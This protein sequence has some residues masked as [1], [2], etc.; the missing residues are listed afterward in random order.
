MEL[1]GFNVSV[2][3]LKQNSSDGNKTDSYYDFSEYAQ[4]G[5]GQT[6][7][8]DDTIDTMNIVLMGLPFRKS[9]EPTSLFRITISQPFIDDDNNESKFEKVYDYAL[10]QDD[11]EQPDMSDNHYFTHNLTLCNPAIIA[12]QRTVDNI[13]VT[14]KLQDVYLESQDILTIDFNSNVNPQIEDANFTDSWLPIKNRKFGEVGVDLWTTYTSYANRYRFVSPTI[15]Y[16]AGVLSES[17]PATAVYD[18]NLTELK[19]IKQN[20]LYGDGTPVVKDGVTYDTTDHIEFN[21]PL[22]EI[23][24]SES[25]LRNYAFIGYLPVDIIV[26]DTN[27]LSG[28]RTETWYYAYPSKYIQD[29]YH[30]SNKEIEIWNDNNVRVEK[31]VGHYTDSGTPYTFRYITNFNND[32]S[33]ENK[34][35]VVVAYDEYSSEDVIVSN[36]VKNRTI[37]IDFVQDEIHQIDIRIQRHQFLPQQMGSSTPKPQVVWQNTEVFG[38]QQQHTDWKLEE[39]YSFVIEL[40]FCYYP[41]DNYLA[42]LFHQSKQIDAYYLFKKSQLAVMPRLKENGV[43]YYNTDLPFFVSEA[44]KTLL[45]RTQLIESDFNGKNLW[46]VF[47]E[48]GKYIHAKPRISIETDDDNVMTGRFLVSFL[49]YGK[50]DINTINATTDSIFNSRFA[51]EYICELDNYVENYFNLGS[52]VTEV[53]HISSD[54]DDSLIYNDVAKLI[55][56]YPIL[57][58]LSLEVANSSMQVRTIT[59]YLYEYNIYKTLDYDVNKTPSKHRAI[60]YHLG[61]NIIEGMQFVTPQPT[62]VECAYSMKNIIAIAFGINDPSNITIGDYVFRLTYRVKDNVR[63]SITRP[64]LRKY[65]LNSSY[66]YY[67]IHAQFNQQQEKIVSSDNFGLNAYGKLIRTGN[68]TYNYYNWTN[69]INNVMNEGDLYN[70]PDGL[71]YVSKV[72]RVYY[73]EH[74]EENVELTKDFN[75]LSQIIGIPSEPRFYEISERNIVNRDIKFNDYIL[76]RAG[77][78]PQSQIDLSLI[79]IEMCFAILDSDEIPDGVVSIFKGDKDKTYDTLSNYEN[80][81]VYLPLVS[82]SSKNTLTLEWDMEDNYSAGDKSTETN[83]TLK[84]GFNLYSFVNFFN[85]VNDS[86]AYRSKEPVRYVDNYGRADL[87]DFFFTKNYALNYSDSYNIP[88]TKIDDMP[89][90]FGQTQSTRV[91]GGS[92]DEAC[93]YLTIDGMWETGAAMLISN[94]SGYII[95]KDNRE[96]LSFN[97]NTQ[98]LLDSDRIVLGNKLWIRDLSNTNTKVVLLNKELNK[99]DSDLIPLENVIATTN[100]IVYANIVKQGNYNSVSYIYFDII[101][102]TSFSYAEL[103]ECMSYALVRADLVNSN[104]Y[105]VIIGRNVSDILDTTDKITNFVFEAYDKSS[106]MTNRKQL[107]NE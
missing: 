61:S 60:Y 7:N 15:T 11:V 86:Q 56:K 18:T 25:G 2:I 58:V 51:Q 13:S 68:T 94:E 22:I 85:G 20:Y 37:R 50:P 16:P 67:P 36:K 81:Q 89:T 47:S 91:M 14:Y 101:N 71:Y 100:D 75:R 4:I 90:I 34:E 93:W 55:T 87:M 78:I 49:Q 21:A 19:S 95:A 44:D 82:Y 80:Y 96:R 76:V 77:T 43:A 65:L 42:N 12:Q 70:T 62:G 92:N 3:L 105:R 41:Q 10:Q 83:Q 6:L 30:G 32:G 73:S 84:W 31:N 107:D 59:K 99:F 9:F 72:S 35:Y 54:S 26:Y 27:L 38:V 97:Y 45:E 46:E 29:F 74:I 103:S 52:Y 8:L 33:I 104:N 23:E 106:A 63:V 48:I 66:D 40:S 5:L 28:N 17:N 1:K 69:D 88:Q 98:L 79:N 39:D 102:N 57:E 24:A 64:D 53:L